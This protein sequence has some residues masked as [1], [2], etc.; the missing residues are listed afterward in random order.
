LVKRRLSWE[1]SSEDNDLNDI[2][3][4]QQGA[5]QE[6]VNLHF[7]SDPLYGRRRRKKPNLLRLQF[8]WTIPVLRAF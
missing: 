7:T 5:W 1:L 6:D 8:C 3:K 4:D 2:E